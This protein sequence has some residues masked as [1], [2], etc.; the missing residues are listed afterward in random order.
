MSN[1]RQDT[2]GYIVEFVS[3]GRSVK[4]TAFDPVTLTEASVIGA[5]RVPRKQLAELA[6]RKL[7]YV[8]SKKKDPD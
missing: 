6:I 4:V 7:N 2:Q 3:V 5:T 8:L 1:D